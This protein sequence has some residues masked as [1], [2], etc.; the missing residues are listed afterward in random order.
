MTKTLCLCCN[1]AGSAFGTEGFNRIDGALV[2]STPTEANTQ[3][4]FRTGGT[5]SNFI[6]E[7]T[8]NAN[9]ADRTFHIRKNGAN[10]NMVITIP[11]GLTGF[12]QDTSNIDTIVAGDLINVRSGATSSNITYKNI[13]MFFEANSSTDTVSKIATPVLTTNVISTQ[14]FHLAG[15][16]SVSTTEV[17]NKQHIQRKAGKIKNLAVNI[18]TNAR[19]NDFTYTIRANAA[20]TSVTVIIPAGLTGQFEDTVNEY[21]VAVDDKCNYEFTPGNALTESHTAQS[22]SIEFIST[23]GFGQCPSSQDLSISAGGTAHWPIKSSSSNTT[24]EA[25][26]QFKMLKPTR[27][28]ELSLLISTNSTTTVEAQFALRVN[29]ADSALV[30]TVPVGTTGF[31]SDSTHVAQVNADDLVNIQGRGGQVGNIII[32]N[33]NMWTQEVIPTLPTSQHGTSFGGKMGLSHS[34]FVAP[35][36]FGQLD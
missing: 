33:T 30:I 6:V 9:A 31:F 13:G 28:S 29:G 32:R 34:Q 23:E 1:T 22:H 14:Y 20:D 7:P 18:T 8:V 35:P 25:N 5:A 3:I 21:T 19:T 24:T 17:N 11:A 4:V 12:F 27:F 15:S 36:T 10:G 2:G 26:A 16:T